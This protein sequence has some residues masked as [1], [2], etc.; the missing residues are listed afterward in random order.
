MSRV[1][2]S[3]SDTAASLLPASLVV[4]SSPQPM[5]M[6]LRVTEGI[7]GHRKV[8]IRSALPRQGACAKLELQSL[9]THMQIRNDTSRNPKRFRTDAVAVRNPKQFS[10]TCLPQREI[11]NVSEPTRLQCEIRNN[12]REQVGFS[13]LPHASPGFAN[14][15]QREIR[16]DASEPP[17]VA[18]RNPKQF[19][20]TVVIFSAARTL[21]CIRKSTRTVECCSSTKI[22]S[23][24]KRRSD[25]RREAL[26]CPTGR[27]QIIAEP[28]RRISMASRG[29][30]TPL[31]SRAAG[32]Q[33][34]SLILVI[35]LRITHRTLQ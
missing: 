28:G 10:R 8:G 2:L 16:N 1:C 7:S 3:R 22:F 26:S 34:R 21:P 13:N 23:A 4:A 19:S 29:R 33:E 6:N 30:I 32:K 27:V 9:R 15:P 35:V 24:S 31:S 25:P 14:L 12:F 18:A 20:R 11:R 5:F 17:R